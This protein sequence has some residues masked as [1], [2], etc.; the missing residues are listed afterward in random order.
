M[1]LVMTCQS[2]SALK[3]GEHVPLY[4]YLYINLLAYEYKHLHKSICEIS[5]MLCTS[6]GKL[7]TEKQT[8]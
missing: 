8:F 1:L 7:G 2:I 5:D 4:F 3:E 6:D